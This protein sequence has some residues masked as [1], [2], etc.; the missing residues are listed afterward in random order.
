MKGLLLKDGYTLLRQM[1]LFLILIL[2]F[3][4]MPN[5]SGSAFTI[6]YS[7]M[8]PI[9]ALAYDERCGWN[10]FAAMMPYRAEDIVV[11]KYL[12]GY[13]LAGAASL[14]SIVVQYVYHF[15]RHTA[16]GGETLLQIAL[17]FCIATLL[18][19]IN[20]PL[21]FKIGVEK[22]RMAFLLLTAGMVIAIMFFQDKL[23]ASPAFLRNPAMTI[24]IVILGTAIINV[25]SIL[26][27]IRFYSK[28]R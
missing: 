13:I 14:V 18:I 23:T 19:A 27:S 12:L 11:S 25:L 17:F 26:L 7:A 6:V 9:S 10:T 15:I 2:F 20:L 8:L 24:L 3:S 28:K 22:G 1:K 4:L 5:F 21:M 16:W